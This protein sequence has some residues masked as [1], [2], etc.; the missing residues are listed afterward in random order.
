MNQQPGSDSAPITIIYPDGQYIGSVNETLKPHGFGSYHLSNRTITG[1]F[2]N[3][4]ISYGTIVDNTV[5]AK[6]YTGE[7]KKFK[8]H[9]IGTLVHSRGTKTSCWVDD[10]FQPSQ[11]IYGI[12]PGNN[13]IVY[14]NTA[15][16][17]NSDKL[18]LYIRDNSNKKRHIQVEYGEQV[19]VAVLEATA[20]EVEHSTQKRDRDEADEIA[21]ISKSN[22]IGDNGDNGE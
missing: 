22:K 6:S 2:D 13:S 17:F 20:I 11:T 15:V 4:N 5:P 18:K 10:V 9:G 14:N 7:L 12:C 19:K 8:K 21:E 1:R 3:G 16:S